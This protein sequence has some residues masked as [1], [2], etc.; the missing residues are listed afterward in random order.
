MNKD[1]DFRLSLLANDMI[2]G[3]EDNQNGVAATVHRIE[4]AVKAIATTGV[5]VDLTP[6]LNAIADLKAH[7]A[8]VADPSVLA[9]VTKIE[10]AMKA[11][12]SALLGA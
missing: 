4:K 11:Q 10:N 2:G 8:V 6:V 12:G 1:Q 5:P 7:P 3:T 9:I